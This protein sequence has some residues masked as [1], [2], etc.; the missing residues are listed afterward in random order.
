MQASTQHIL[1]SRRH[2]PGDVLMPL[3]SGELA[4]RCDPGRA[5][6]RRKSSTRMTG[7]SAKRAD[8]RAGI[9]SDR[10]PKT[11]GESFIPIALYFCNVDQRVFAQP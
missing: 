2:L 7:L 11:A 1:S 9:S 4:R 10:Y 3:E 8:S 5:M 6:R